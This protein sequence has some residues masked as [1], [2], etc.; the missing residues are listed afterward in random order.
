MLEQ[1][2]CIISIQKQLTVKQSNNPLLLSG[3]DYK[4]V[5]SRPVKESPAVKR[6][7]LEGYFFSQFEIKL[8]L[9]MYGHS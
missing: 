3:L 7:F 6:E 8:M 2:A 1:D 4:P 9:R 5:F